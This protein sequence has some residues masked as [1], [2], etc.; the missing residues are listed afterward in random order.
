RNLKLRHLIRP[1]ARCSTR[2]AEPRTTEPGRAPA[3]RSHPPGTT[4]LGLVVLCALAAAV[5]LASAAFGAQPRGPACWGP[6]KNGCSSILGPLG[7]NLNV[8]GT[9]PESIFRFVYAHKCLGTA[10]NLANEV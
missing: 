8:S 2:K 4:R 6:T 9:N 1:R 5:V 3:R 7:G 10:N